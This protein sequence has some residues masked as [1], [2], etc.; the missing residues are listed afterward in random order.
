[1]LEEIE[2]KEIKKCPNC[3]AEVTGKFCSNCGYKLEEKEK[4]NK[5]LQIAVVILTTIT[6]VCIVSLAYLIS[7]TMPEASSETFETLSF[8]CVV[9]LIAYSSLRL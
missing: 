1:M 4:N 9:S 2:E 5:K 8:Q 7:Q 3:G 6:I